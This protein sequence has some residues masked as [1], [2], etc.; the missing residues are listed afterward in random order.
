M[1]NINSAVTTKKLAFY[2][3]MHALILEG[4]ICGKID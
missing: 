2:I 1:K 3:F 4:K